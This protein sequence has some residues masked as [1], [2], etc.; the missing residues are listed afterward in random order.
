M[1]A[2]STAIIRQRTGLARWWAAACLLVAGCAGVPRIDPTGE[3]LLVW[4]SPAP[5]PGVPAGDFPP[6]P[7]TPPLPGSL[8]VVAPCR[9]RRWGLSVSP[10]QTIAPVGSEVVLIASV[11]GNEGF[12]LNNERIEWMLAPDGVGQFLSPGQRSRWKS[13]IGCTDCRKKST[14]DTW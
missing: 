3:R 9:R 6:P 8:P 14:A 2:D 4:P 12:L 11:S 5:P 1:S 7:G 13:F 10:T